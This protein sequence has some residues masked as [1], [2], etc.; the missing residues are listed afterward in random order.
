MIA[1][2]TISI[3]ALMMDK[4]QDLFVKCVMLQLWGW[5][6]IKQQIEKK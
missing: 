3:S 1:S 6:L 5:L 4:N 2:S